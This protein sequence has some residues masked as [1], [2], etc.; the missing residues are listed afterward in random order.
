MSTQSCWAVL[1]QAC[2][3]AKSFY[4]RGL[5]TISKAFAAKCII[6]GSLMGWTRSGN[7]CAG[8][9]DLNIHV[10]H[11]GDC[12]PQALSAV[13]I[14]RD[15]TLFLSKIQQHPG[16]DRHLQTAAIDV[17]RV[18]TVISLEGLARTVDTLLCATCAKAVS[19]THSDQSQVIIEEKFWRSSRPHRGARYY[20]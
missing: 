10:E 2:T 20:G 17:V 15:E 4:H 13:M 16:N 7:P 9:R 18:L 1:S 3:A 8:C 6:H 14:P 5:L 19:S 12:N 11:M